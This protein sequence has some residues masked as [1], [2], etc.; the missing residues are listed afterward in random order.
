MPF[1]AHFLSQSG[2]QNDVKMF[3]V[4]RSAKFFGFFD[5]SRETLGAKFY[6]LRDV[7][8]FIFQRKKIIPV[9]FDGNFALK[10]ADMP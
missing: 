10:R 2:G 1:S 7:D 5:V 4:K 6:S 9:A 8:I 3:H